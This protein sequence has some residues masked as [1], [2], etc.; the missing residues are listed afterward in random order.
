M[1]T[2]NFISFCR[3]AG[4]PLTSRL[5]SLATQTSS[6]RNRLLFRRRFP[7]VDMPCGSSMR[8]GP[9][10]GRYATRCSDVRSRRANSRWP[11]KETGFFT[12]RRIYREQSIISRLAPTW[13]WTSSHISAPVGVK[14][15]DHQQQ[16]LA[17][18]G[19]V[20][21]VPQAV[22]QKLKNMANMDNIAPHTPWT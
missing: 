6:L 10:A 3:T 18:Q 1:R 4:V 17:S 5:S 21:F 14:N 9:S 7:Q 11:A 8:A 12:W 16:A 15:G 2:S 19:R 22:P 20:K 13:T